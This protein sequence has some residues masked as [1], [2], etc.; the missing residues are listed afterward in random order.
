[1][2]PLSQR[3]KISSRLGE[4]RVSFD[5]DIFEKEIEERLNRAVDYLNRPHNR[6]GSN[7]GS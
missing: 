3:R 4:R 6:K 2:P 7:V 5:K 1:M